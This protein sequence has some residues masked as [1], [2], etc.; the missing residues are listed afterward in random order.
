MTTRFHHVRASS[1]QRR[2]VIRDV[3]LD[4]HRA[5]HDAEAQNYPSPSASRACRTICTASSSCGM[6]EPEKIGSFCP[7]ISVAE[8]VDGGDAGVDIIPRT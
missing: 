8:R 6:P 5:E 2:E 4:P 7:R 3:V 1:K